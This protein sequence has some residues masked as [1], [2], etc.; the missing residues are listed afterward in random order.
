MREHRLKHSELSEEQ[1]KKANAR[2]YVNAN[3]KKG[4]IEKKPCEICGTTNNLEKHHKDYS[5][6]MDIQ[7]L[8]RQHH[9]AV[10]YSSP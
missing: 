7:W 1:R 9:L 4:R 10:H 6:P 8:C 3:L 2:S 5:K